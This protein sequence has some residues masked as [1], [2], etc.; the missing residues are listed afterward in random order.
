M[1][2]LSSQTVTIPP[3]T[4]INVTKDLKLTVDHIEAPQE[5]GPPI[6]HLD[7]HGYL[8]GRHLAAS[9]SPLLHST[10]FRHL[11]LNWEQTRLDSSDMSNFLRLVRH[12]RCFGASVT[13]PHKITIIRHLDVLTNECRQVGACN[14]IFLRN[15]PATGR[16]LLCGANT[17]VA[18]V[19]E[20]FLHSGTV[21]DCWQGRPA[22]VIGGGGAA[23]SAVYALRKWLGVSEIYLL[24]R[25]PEETKELVDECVAKGFG[26][27]LVRLESVAQAEALDVP[28]AIVACIP[29]HEPETEGERLVRGIAQTV[30][31]RRG[32]TQRDGAMLEMCYNPSPY[33]ALGKLAEDAGWRVI[34]GTEALIWQ[35]LEQDKYWTGLDLPDLPVSEVHEAIASELARHSIAQSTR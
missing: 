22:M 31:M 6:D 3:S 28:G 11:N 12:P 8:F 25:D 2:L 33:T 14:T 34:L 13:M 30:L 17:D 5:E 35:G 15:D 29:N 32:A 27:G 26:E 24:N 4:P 21:S 20:A 18:G 16:R 19:R 7:R 23:R 9:M 1:A 10:V